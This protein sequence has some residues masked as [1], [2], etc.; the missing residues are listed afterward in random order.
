MWDMRVSEN[1]IAHFD[2][3]DPTSYQFW[4]VWTHQIVDNKQSHSGLSNS[5]FSWPVTSRNS[6]GISM[7][8]LKLLSL[9]CLNM[10]V[11]KTRP[12]RSAFGKDPVQRSGQT[13]PSLVGYVNF[14]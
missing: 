8:F 13:L 12:N 5:R 11:G 10:L 6:N 14:V 2:C 7:H 1:V 3:D 4:E 9:V